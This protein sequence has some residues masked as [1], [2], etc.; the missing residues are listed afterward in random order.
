MK[1]ALFPCLMLGLLLFPN[2]MDAQQVALSAFDHSDKGIGWEFTDLFDEPEQFEASSSVWQFGIGFRSD[3]NLQVTSDAVNQLDVKGLLPALTLTYERQVWNNV[4]VG[5][6]VGYQMWKVPIFGYQYRYY[7]GALRAA[8]H[9][10]VTDQLD[11]YIGGCA[12]FRRL[13]LANDGNNLHNWKITGSFLIG[14]RYYLSER[15]GLVFEIG[16]EGPSWFKG[17]VAFYLPK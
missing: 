5:L 11:P 10:N 15:F 17:G 6:T 7:T 16:D 14:V 3:L 13:D 4:G 9:F 1:K 8:Y 12:T 2:W